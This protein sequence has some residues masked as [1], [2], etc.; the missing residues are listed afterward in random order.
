MS[1]FAYA[2]P[3]IHDDLST[4]SSHA[5]TD[6]L[7]S[8]SPPAHHPD[9]DEDTHP[10]RPRPHNP[11]A[12]RSQGPLIPTIPDLRFEQS[13]MRSI[14]LHLHL[15]P[16]ADVE[17]Q[18]LRRDVAPVVD[19]ARKIE[20]VEWAQVVWVTTRD[21]VISPFLQGALWSVSVLPPFSIRFF[22]FVLI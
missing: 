17:V 2:H 7:H 13:Y 5:D 6:S 14:R 9:L 4:S 19:A 20:S 18:G 21:Q 11:V 1:T 16:R 12:P 3:P 8:R 22:P 15:S 10:L